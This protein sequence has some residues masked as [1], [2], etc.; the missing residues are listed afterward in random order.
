MSEKNEAGEL[1]SC[2]I[3][4]DDTGLFIGRVKFRSYDTGRLTGLTENS[5]RS[6]FNQLLQLSASGA[7]V[8]DG[9]VL[10]GYHNNDDKGDVLLLDGEF[11]GTWYSDDF[12]WSY[13]IEPGND[14][15]TCSAPSPWMLQDAI[16]VWLRENSLQ[17]S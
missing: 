6:Q 16:T 5:I 2:D 13:F 15:E 17:A 14:V 7:M 12:E 3:E 1:F 10:T 8:R 9:V 11:I 4:I